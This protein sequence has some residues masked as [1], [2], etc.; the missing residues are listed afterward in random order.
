MYFHVVSVGTS[1]YL[2]NTHSSVF[3]LFPFLPPSCASCEKKQKSNII[4]IFYQ[5]SDVNLFDAYKKHLTALSL[6]LLSS[7][8]FKGNMHE[9]F[10]LDIVTFYCAYFN[11]YLNCLFSIKYIIDYLYCLP[12]FG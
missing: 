10:L 7:L 2:C 3:D 11:S 12:F 5:L 9:L 1:R 4:F 6:C 8:L